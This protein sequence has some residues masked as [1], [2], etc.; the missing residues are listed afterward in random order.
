MAVSVASFLASFPEFQ[1]A[2]TNMLTATL[3]SVE[4]QVSDSW[5]DQRDRAVMLRLADRLANSP[6]GRDARMTAD[7]SVPKSTY[8]VEFDQLASVNALSGSRLGSP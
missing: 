6:W 2:G 3:A 4:L 1:A 7:G 5:G 8:S